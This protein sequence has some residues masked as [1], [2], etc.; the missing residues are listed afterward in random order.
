[1]VPSL[2][3]TAS[4]PLKTWMFERLINFTFGIAYLQG[5]CYLCSFLKGIFVKFIVKIPQQDI[6]QCPKETSWR[7]LKMTST[8]Y[9]P[10]LVIWI[11]MTGQCH[12]HT[13]CLYSL[14][15]EL[16]WT[17]TPPLSRRPRTALGRNPCKS[18]RILVRISHGVIWFNLKFCGITSNETMTHQSNTTKNNE[19][20]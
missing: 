20:I 7:G 13:R 2:K 12:H 19:N 6:V 9:N 1:M 4:L 16:W 3:L 5:V 15:W 14:S 11:M 17:L 8:I 10:V 18:W